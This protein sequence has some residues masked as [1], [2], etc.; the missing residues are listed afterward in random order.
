MATGELS[1]PA[2]I[3]RLEL[4]VYGDKAA[5]PPRLGVVDVIN[6]HTR[7]IFGAQDEKEPGLVALVKEYIGK[8]DDLSDGKKTLLTLLGLGVTA[9]GSVGSLL[10]SVAALY[11]ALA[12]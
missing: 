10:A 2:R 6:Q 8:V 11:V 4:T 3:S 5:N 12:K 9:F 7:V 1:D